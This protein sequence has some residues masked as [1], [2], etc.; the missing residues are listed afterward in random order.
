MLILHGDHDSLVPFAQSEELADLLKKD[1]VEVN[2][3]KLPRSGH[4]GPAFSLPAVENLIAQ[5][6]DKHLKG[7]DA[8]IE[9]L[10]DSEFTPKPKAA[11]APK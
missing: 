1:G 6:L 9:P 3:Q 5:F 8:K 7:I 10:P 2:L 4:G 11:P